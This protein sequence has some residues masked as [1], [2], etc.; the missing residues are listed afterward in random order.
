MHQRDTFDASTASAPGPPVAPAFGIT[1]PSDTGSDPAAEARR[2]EALGFDVVTVHRDVLH[3]APAAAETW[4]LLTWVAAH[5]TRVALLPDVLALPNRHPAVLAKMA[6]SLDRLTGHRLI[7]GLGAGAPMNDE[8]LRALGLT[9]P[10]GGGRLEALE[11]AID[12]IR[13]L[14]DTARFSYAGR[15]FTTVDGRLQPR[16][17]RPIPIWIGAFGPRMLELAGRKADGWL[18]SMHLLPPPAAYESRRR[19][20]VAAAASGR[21]PDSITCGYNV[22]VLVQ[23]GARSTERTI[24]GGPAEVAEQLAELIAGGFTFLN[25]WPARDRAEQHDRLALEVLPLVRRHHPT[26]RT[27]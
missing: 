6:E 25:L 24:A 2:A 10:T 17:S 27:S 15:H 14:W 23:Q 19:V 21:D 22:G 16:P 8:A 18:P 26:G 13:G 11:E 4:T 1:V 9:V 3:G 5:T 12:V 20:R 7:L